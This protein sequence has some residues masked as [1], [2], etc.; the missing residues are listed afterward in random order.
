M[1]KI[2]RVLALLMAA[3]MA[4]GLMTTAFAAE[5]ER[6]LR[7]LFLPWNRAVE[8]IFLWRR[9]QRLYIVKTSERASLGSA[10]GCF[11]FMKRSNS[12]KAGILLAELRQNRF[13]KRLD[14]IEMLPVIQ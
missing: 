13:C 11:C 7:R 2:H 4:F 8:A 14:L 3:L 6:R 5:P 9:Q 10:F 12:R 1:K